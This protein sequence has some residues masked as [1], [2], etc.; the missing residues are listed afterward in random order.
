MRLLLDTSVMVAMMVAAHPAHVRAM[1]CSERLLS[2]RNELFL[3]AHSLAEL[4]AVL[5]RMPTSPKIGPD[6]AKRLIHENIESASIRIVTLD[7]ADYVAVLDG[8]AK[9]GLSGG[10]IYDMLIAQAARKAKADRIMTLNEAD[11]AR[12]CRNESITVATP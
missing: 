3:C 8:M 9:S 11:F 1:R 6:L 5:T 7:A 2:K 10:I 4:F 12:V